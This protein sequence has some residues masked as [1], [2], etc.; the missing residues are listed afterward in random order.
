MSEF[1][2]VDD[3]LPDVFA[4]D[5]EPSEVISIDIRFKVV[6]LL[7]LAAFCGFPFRFDAFNVPAVIQEIA[8]ADENGTNEIRFAERDGVCSAVGDWADCG[9]FGVRLMDSHADRTSMREPL[10]RGR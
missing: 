2:S 1:R 10:V 8:D 9:L 7:C 5:A 3:G 6:G 4:R